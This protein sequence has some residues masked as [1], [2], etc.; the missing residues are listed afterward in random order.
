MSKILGIVRPSKV[1]ADYMHQLIWYQTHCV[2]HTVFCIFL[3]TNKIV[4]LQNI[5][6]SIF[7]MELI[8]VYCEVGNTFQ[9]LCKLILYLER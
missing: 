2:V 6:I 4:Y 5:N 9:E 7:I 1:S 3:A 8:G